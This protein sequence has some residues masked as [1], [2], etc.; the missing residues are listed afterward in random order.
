MST[1]AGDA[2]ALILFFER[3]R[4]RGGR[5]TAKPTD[6]RRSSADGFAVR[7]KRTK[8]GD[9]VVKSCSPFSAA[10]WQRQKSRQSRGKGGDFLRSKKYYSA[11]TVWIGGTEIE[12]GLSAA[13]RCAIL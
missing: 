13:G 5:A 6:S 2:P 8:A 7:M 1:P 3:G 9:R 4:G 11:L 10:K 12:R